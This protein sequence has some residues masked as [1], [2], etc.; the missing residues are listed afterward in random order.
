MCEPGR[1]P[2]EVQLKIIR[3]ASAITAHYLRI[4]NS[5]VSDPIRRRRHDAPRVPAPSPIGNTPPLK[6]ILAFPDRAGF[7][8]GPKR[9]VSGR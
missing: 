1:L 2:A 7:A 9:A 8:P 4:I 3:R 5:A 6:P